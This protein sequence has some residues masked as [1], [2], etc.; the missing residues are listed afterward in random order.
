MIT[1]SKVMFFPCIKVGILFLPRRGMKLI[2]QPNST[3]FYSHASL[4]NYLFLSKYYLFSL[5]G[6]NSRRL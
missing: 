3:V 2:L 6:V 5:V 4:Y 1:L